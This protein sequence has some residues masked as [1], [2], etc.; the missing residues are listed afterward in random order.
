MK[1]GSILWVAAGLSAI[2]SAAWYFGARP[3]ANRD[4]YPPWAVNVY[5]DGSSS[6]F[7]LRLEHSTVAEALP[8]ISGNP[9]LALVARANELPR[10]EVYWPD[11]RLSGFAGKLIASTLDTPAD[12]ANALWEARRHERMDDGAQKI[13][14]QPQDYAAALN[15]RIESFVFLPSY[16][17]KAEQIESRFGAPAEKIAGAQAEHWLYPQR[18]IDLAYS[19]Q[20]KEVIQYVS[21]RVFERVRAPLLEAMQANPSQENAPQ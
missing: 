15:N 14:L 1:A 10:L 4:F 9:E 17:L 2:T 20:H 3:D 16:N 5:E 6:V 21:P 18:G 12:W 19:E 11:A 13:T 7:S 8:R